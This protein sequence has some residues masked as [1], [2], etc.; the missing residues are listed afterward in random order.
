MRETIF[1]VY[2]YFLFGHPLYFG[3]VDMICVIC[4]VEDICFYLYVLCFSFSLQIV[5]A[6]TCIRLFF[7]LC[8]LSMHEYYAFYDMHVLRGSFT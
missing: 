4:V 3:I 1:C 5:M 2:L 6:W 8:H 7:H